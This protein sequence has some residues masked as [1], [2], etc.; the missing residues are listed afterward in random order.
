MDFP[1]YNPSLE[2][3]YEIAGN[4]ADIARNYGSTFYA[5]CN[6]ELVGVNGI[7]KANCIDGELLSS[8]A[9]EPCTLKKDEG[10]RPDCGCTKSR[11]IGSYKHMPCYHSCLYCYANPAPLKSQT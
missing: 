10:Q 6:D 8:L 2:E 9:G 5:C 4:L 11:D 1:F 7:E 3:R